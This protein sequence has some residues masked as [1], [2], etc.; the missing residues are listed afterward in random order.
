MFK[1][2]QFKDVHCDVFLRIGAGNWVK[3]AETDVE[4]RIGARGEAK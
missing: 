3:F 2:P 1:H 4:R